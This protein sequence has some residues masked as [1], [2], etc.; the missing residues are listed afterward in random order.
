MASLVNSRKFVSQS[1]YA[2]NPD[3][4]YY[5]LPFRFHSISKQKEV[6]V[7]EVGDYLIVPTGTAKSIAYRQIDYSSNLYRDLVANF[8][9]SPTP[10]PELLEVLA[11]RYRT[12]KHFLQ[13]FT[14]LHIFVVSLRCNHTCH[15]CQV[16]RAT[17]NKS[18]FDIS[19]ADLDAGIDHMFLSP[20]HDLT[21]EFQ[22]G[23][24]LLAF[25]KVKYGVER[26]LELN[27]IYKRNISFVICTN[28][29][30][31][32]DDILQFCKTYNILI[33]TSLD[34]PAF[35]HNANRFKSGRASH[36]MV[37][38][39]IKR[40]R[41]ALGHEKVSALMTTTPLS[42]KYPKE[43]I[44]HYLENE[45]HNIFLRPISPYG[46]AKKN[47]KKNNY[48]TDEFLNFYKQGLDYILELNQSGVSIREDYT[49]IILQ[50][51]LSPFNVNYVDL[52]SP[53]GIVTS[54]VV[55]NYDGN[56]YASDESRMLAES[57]DYTFRLGHVSQ[58]YA[59]LFFSSK[60]KGLLN[61]GISECLAGCRDCAFLPF[62][63]ADPVV[64]YASQNDMEGNRAFS[65]FC[66]KNM[67][68]IRHIFELLDQG[69][70]H[71]ESFF[72]SWINPKLLEL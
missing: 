55:F 14:A 31:L 69:G 4:T 12:K 63:G 41:Q 47:L 11:S 15:Y 16:S 13:T 64:H 6:L 62:C 54:V 17:E 8:F 58:P 39:G 23:E 53:S 22:G 57:H 70:L 32:S 21:M 1:D 10:I 29:T 18:A 36:E 49:S 68:I 37:V 44:D 19:F 25:E 5:L 7:N 40:A 52:Q 46:F 20:S 26:A 48:Q 34:G 66:K 60:S 56:V 51:I 3:E 59:E 2:P 24:P 42:L 72:R 38:E 50:K 35:I 30:I 71:T 61:S 27:E 43:I 9:I 28:L 33:S 45:F 65:I 67:E